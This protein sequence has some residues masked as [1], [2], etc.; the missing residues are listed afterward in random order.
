[1]TRIF[2]LA[3]ACCGGAPENKAGLSR[4]AFSKVIDGKNVYLWTLVNKNG[5]EMTVTNYGGKVVSLLVP[6]KTGKLVDVVTG[7]N[8]IDDFLKSGEIYFGATIGRYGNRIANGKFSIDGV[9][10][11]LATNNGPNNLHGGVKGFHAVV[12]DAK[13]IDKSTLELSYLAKDG[14]EGFP[15]NLNVKVVYKITDD[16]E[17]TIEY[18][19]ETD[20]KTVCNMTNHAY[21]NLSGEGSETA[22]DHILQIDADG[23]TPSNSDLI[24]LG[25]VEP[26]EGT[27]MDFRKPE[28]IGSRISEDYEP[29][30]F[31]YGYDHNFVINKKEGEIAHAA[32]LVSP[33]TGIKMEVFTDQPGIQLY[34]GNWMNGTEI[35]KSGKAYKYRAAVCLETQ[36]FP[37]SPNQ[38]QFPSTLL[39]PGQTYRHTTIHKFSIE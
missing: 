37:D 26:V 31:G 11:P 15:G 24:P 35:G 32:T 7:Y 2:L 13:Q 12:W 21:F 18:Y 34:S 38:P 20:K 39:E 25:N 5:M 33:V 27:P 4:S 16:N 10:Y 23:F 22:M 29:L 1:V 28:V 3:C 9:E 14:E 19:A 30:K 6:D 8:S 17:F 36:H